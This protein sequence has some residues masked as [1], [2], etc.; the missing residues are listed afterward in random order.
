MLPSENGNAPKIFINGQK[1]IHFHSTRY[2]IIFKKIFPEK[3]R[4][5]LI[6]K[7]LTYTGPEKISFFHR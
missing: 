7:T 5:V 1:K 2:E 3:G 6:Q 4:T